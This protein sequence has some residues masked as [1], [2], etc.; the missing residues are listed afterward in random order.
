[1]RGLFL[2]LDDDHCNGSNCRHSRNANNDPN[3]KGLGLFC[4]TEV[5]STIFIGVG[6]KETYLALFVSIPR[7]FWVFG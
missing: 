4:A 5:A 1:M 2:F 3:H 6:S 7:L